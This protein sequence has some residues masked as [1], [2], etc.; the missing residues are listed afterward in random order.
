MNTNDKP[1]KIVVK[2][3]KFELHTKY[4]QEHVGSKEEE[5]KRPFP[6]LLL[7]SIRLSQLNKLA[8]NKKD[9]QYEVNILITQ[10]EANTEKAAIKLKNEE[11]EVNKILKEDKQ[12]TYE[13]PGEIK[14]FTISY[15][16]KV[17]WKLIRLLVLYDQIVKKYLILWKTAGIDKNS[18]FSSIK[19][20]STTIR[21]VMQSFNDAAKQLVSHQNNLRS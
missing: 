21:K 16:P 9:S 2:A 18:C 6:S 13:L 12:I 17:L 14:S 8:K 15:S 1:K 5:I 3:A 4:A 11:A 10:L 19:R 7:I 20:I